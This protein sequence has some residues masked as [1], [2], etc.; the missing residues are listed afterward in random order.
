MKALAAVLLFFALV[1]CDVSADVVAED[2]LRL[3]PA[4]LAR[5][6]PDDND[7][8]AA[9]LVRAPDNNA[10]S[11]VHWPA[12]RGFRKAQ[13]TGPMPRG[14][15]GVI[16]THPSWLPRPSAQDVAE[17]ERLGL[18]FYVVSRAAFCSVAPGKKIT[19]SQDVPWVVSFRQDTTRARR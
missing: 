3:A 5:S 1:V 8:S 14:V 19:C 18:P 7:E 11:L 4:V 16:H 10:V 15:I 13:W 17:A 9:F 12:Q 6:G 2:A